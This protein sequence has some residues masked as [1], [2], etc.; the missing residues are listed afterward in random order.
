MCSPT[1]KPDPEGH[2][3]ETFRGIYGGIARADEQERRD[4]AAGLGKIWDTPTQVKPRRK[5]NR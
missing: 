3:R 5:G 4:R 1:P 2:R